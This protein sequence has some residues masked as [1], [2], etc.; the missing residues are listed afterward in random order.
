MATS[1]DFIDKLFGS[2]IRARVLKLFFHNP[3]SALTL[4]EISSKTGVGQTDV[5]H[6]VH[7]LKKLNLI[8]YAKAKKLQKKK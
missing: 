8:R 7:I 4:G 2:K 3:L 5:R 1:E 6:A